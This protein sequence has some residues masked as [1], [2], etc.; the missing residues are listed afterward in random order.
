MCTDC[1]VGG[2]GQQLQDAF[3]ASLTANGGNTPTAALCFWP[4][5]DVQTVSYYFSPHSSEIVRD[6]IER[7]AGVPC[8][9]PPRPSL[10]THV[11][12]CGGDPRALEL[13][14]PVEGRET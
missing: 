1:A 5:H 7:F 2:T 12:L 14:W 4:S 13:L 3:E 11:T 9:R 8:E 6:L 10:D